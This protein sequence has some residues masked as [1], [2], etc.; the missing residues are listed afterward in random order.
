VNKY[1]GLLLAE[2]GFES[3]RLTVSSTSPQKGGAFT[4]SMKSPRK[5]KEYREGGRL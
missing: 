5:K 4:V 3:K 1:P 2:E